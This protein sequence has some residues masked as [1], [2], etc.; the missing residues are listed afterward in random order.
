MIR[1]LA[2]F[3]RI[4]GVPAQY[5]G[6]SWISYGLN[7]ALAKKGVVV[8]DKAFKNLTTSELQQRGAS[9]TIQGSLSG[10]PVYIRGSLLVGKSEI[11][12]AQFSKLLKQVTTH[13]SSVSDI[14]VHDGSLGSCPQTDAKVR[15]ISDSPA[16]AC[17]FHDILWQTHMRAVSH[18]SSP[19]TVY[20]AS[21]ISSS[22]VDALG[23]GSE[24]NNGLI[25]AD[26]D[27]SFLILCGKAFCNAN[28]VKNALA[29]LAEPIIISRGGLLLHAS[30]L[31]S[32]NSVFLMFVSEDTVRGCSEQVVADHGGV[33]MSPHG[34]S[35]LFR[36]RNPGSLFPFKFPAAIVLASSDSSGL[37]PTIS[38]LSP[39]QA[40]YHF[41]AGYQNGTFNPAY[42]MSSS[43]L[44]DPLQ[45]AKALFSKLV[46]YQIPSFL[47]NV[48]EG[49]KQIAGM[50]FVNLVESSLHKN[51]APFEPP[52]GGDLGRRYKNF[53][54]SKF[55][56]LPQHLS[57]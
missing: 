55:G 23:L 53:V 31:L 47:I 5:L 27:Q 12:K 30:I 24:V 11:T 2:L 46:D 51:I 3:T 33:I 14:F 13:I 8:K 1:F 25:A 54:A 16:A 50:D 34:V 9:A 42:G 22:A 57:F 28:G 36:T 17:T 21:S 29:A 41:L 10:L 37:I 26:T 52:R 7:L 44:C 15:V 32:C 20:V 39:G 40:A 19:V 38:K 6:R 49:E 45:I 4:Q 56:K 43:Y 48:N 35:T 18:D